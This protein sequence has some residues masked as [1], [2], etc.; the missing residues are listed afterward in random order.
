MSR[1]WKKPPFLDE[2]DRREGEKNLPSRKMK[3]LTVI[4]G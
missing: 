1:K 3:I 2:I 4:I